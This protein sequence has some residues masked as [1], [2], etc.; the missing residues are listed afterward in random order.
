MYMHKE[1]FDDVINS[2]EERMWHQM[3]ETSTEV[4]NKLCT[5]FKGKAMQT[6]IK[7]LANLYFDEYTDAVNFLES[8]EITASDCA[9]IINHFD[10]YLKF[11]EEEHGEY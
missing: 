1:V 11:Y 8:Y 5:A 4:E 10:K 3:L 2:Y 9:A 7:M 6:I